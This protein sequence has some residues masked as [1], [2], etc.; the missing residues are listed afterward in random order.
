MAVLQVYLLS[1][2]VVCI[3]SSYMFSNAI[4]INNGAYNVS[5]HFNESADTLEFLVE[6]SATGWVGFGFSLN[7]SVTGMVGYDVAVGGVLSN[8]TGYL[9]DYF[10]NGTEQPPEDSQQDWVLIN[11][12]EQSG[13]TT[14]KFYRKRN[15]SD[16]NDIAIEQGVQV[17][18][19]WAYKSTDDV[20][21]ESGMF[22]RHTERGVEGPVT[23]I[24]TITSTMAEMPTTTIAS[25]TTSE[26]PRM[27]AMTTSAVIEVGPPTMVEMTT[28]AMEGMTT[29]VLTE[30]STSTLVEM[31]TTTMASMTTSEM[32][33]MVTTTETEDY[34]TRGVGAPPE[35]TKQDWVLTYSGE[36]NGITTLQFYRK[37]NT[38]D[39]NDTV[40][41]QGEPIFLI[42]AYHSTSDVQTGQFMK[43]SYRGVM[44]V[45][46]IP[47]PTTAATTQNEMTEWSLTGGGR[48]QES[49]YR[50]P[51]P[52]RGPGTSTLWKI[53]YCILYLSY[54]IFFKCVLDKKISHN[55]PTSAPTTPTPVQFVNMAS[56]D[57]GNY[58][59][60]WMFNSSMNTLH[61][62]V[63]VRATGWVGFGVATQAPNNMTYY[64]V[65]VGGVVNG[66]GYL[67][68]YLTRG[69]GAPPEDTKQ[70]WVLTYSREDNGITT[71]QFYR[72][73]NTSDANDTVIQQGVPIFLIWA[74]HKT[75][76]VQTGQFMKHSYRGVMQITLIP[77]PTTPG[78]FPKFDDQKDSIFFHL[79]VKTTGW[80]GFGFA[81]T[82]PRNMMNYDV[83]V[84][85][86][87]NGQGYLNDYFTRGQIQPTLDASPDYQLLNASEVGGYT[88][89]MFERRRDTGD[90]DNDLTFMVSS[91][92]F[93]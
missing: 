33:A 86:Y 55:F 30:V 56:F 29:S 1:L 65:A 39:A 61:F 14:L 76:D 85:G 13:V 44:Q 62:T 63:E 74:Y 40:I 78:E 53:I 84:G 36:D 26:M 46:F 5:Y 32:P 42:W 90:N 57:N 35:D 21:P 82:E 8:G 47:A 18:I 45:T 4:I 59:V 87:S 68:D 71:L 72:K 31:T 23:L 16:S 2:F 52:R 75:S 60:S 11:S 10:T 54:E 50:A 41:Q 38:S 93:L 48:L 92:P 28:S 80:I 20:D 73:L 9:R 22:S 66:S 19:V 6:A 3:T 67:T 27:A 25:M 15:T 77:P 43:H 7:A 88:E 81:E 12:N 24:P 83:I 89:L 70:D 34:L 64:D 58:N 17:Y 37:L 51:L 49:N 69:V 79:R 91:S